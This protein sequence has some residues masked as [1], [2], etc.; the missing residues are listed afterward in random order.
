MA[1]PR[2]CLWC[3]EFKV[4]AGEW[5]DICP[6]C[7]LNHGVVDRPELPDVGDCECW[8]DGSDNKIHHCQQRRA[9]AQKQAIEGK[10]PEMPQCAICETKPEYVPRN[11]VR[12]GDI[13]VSVCES[14]GKEYYAA[15]TKAR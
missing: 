9:L 10:E 6:D 5:D 3:D 4:V 14:C 15:T 12:F 8:F 13:V 11:P 2:L 1:G 7:K